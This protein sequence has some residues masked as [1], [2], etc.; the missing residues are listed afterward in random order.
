MD[1]G[2]SY[3]GLLPGTDE[4]HERL[5][6]ACAK[7]LATYNFG[8]LRVLAHNSVG[9]TISEGQYTTRVVYDANDNP[10]YVGLTKPG[11][12]TAQASWQIKQITYDAND[13]PTDVKWADGD[14]G[15]DNIMDNYA[16]L[17]YS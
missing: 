3:L 2:P 10:I 12:T 5:L 1:T 13:N 9:Q 16:V 14:D 8:V 4:G 11:N 15:F 6:N 17:S 7:W